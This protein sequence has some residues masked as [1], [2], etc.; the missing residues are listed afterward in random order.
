MMLEQ[1]QNTGRIVT[2]DTG[3]LLAQLETRRNDTADARD[4]RRPAPF[5]FVLRCWL[6]RRRERRA[7]RREL[8][9]MPDCMLK[10]FGLTYGAAEAI[11]NTPFWRE[12]AA[13]PVR[14]HRRS[15]NRR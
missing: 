15:A 2:L 5:S 3:A 13:T 6:A 9:T 14:T 10:D 11:A 8:P 4:D 12:T 7:L 1:S